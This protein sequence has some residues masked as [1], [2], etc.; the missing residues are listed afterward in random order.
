MPISFAPMW[1]Y[2]KTHGISSYYLMKHGID[3][4]TIQRIRHNEP[5]TTLTLGKLC[6]IMQCTPGDLICYQEDNE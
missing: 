1:A 3:A 5:I 4:Q 2:M 6:R